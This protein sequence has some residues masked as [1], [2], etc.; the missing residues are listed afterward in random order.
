MVRAQRE[1][2][3]R[4][5]HFE[6]C[7]FCLPVK[8]LS[9]RL[10]EKGTQENGPLHSSKPATMFMRGLSSSSSDRLAKMLLWRKKEIRKG[11]ELFENFEE[12]VDLL[13]YT[14]FFSCQQFLEKTESKNEFVSFST[15]HDSPVLSVA[16]SAV[17]GGDYW[18][19]A[20]L[21]QGN[22]DVH[23]FLFFLKAYWGLKQLCSVIGI[24]SDVRVVRFLCYK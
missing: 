12:H 22:K 17:P 18:T 2:E 23:S 19:H 11:N 9:P 21:E 7:H 14:V 24:T 3:T 16:H 6:I 4:R 20:A 10:G 15:C 8:P 13:Q 1:R 5:Q